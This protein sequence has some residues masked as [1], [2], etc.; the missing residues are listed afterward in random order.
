MF[1]DADR[2]KFSE[3]ALAALAQEMGQGPFGLPDDANESPFANVDER[4]P[5]PTRA[6][7]QEELGYQ[8]SPVARYRLGSSALSCFQ[9]PTKTNA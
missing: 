4:Y 2:G 7:L 1:V 3:A 9:L 6:T 8:L 5:D